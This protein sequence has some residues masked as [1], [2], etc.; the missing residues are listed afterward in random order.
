[1]SREN[2]RAKLIAVASNLLAVEG[3]SGIR[4]AEIAKKAKVRESTIFYHFKDRSDLIEAAQLE[5]YRSTY[6]AVVEPM[7]AALKFSD[8][9]QQWESAVRKV[10][11]DSFVAGREN[12]RSTRTSVLGMAQTSGRLR[13]E[14]VQ[15]NREVIGHVSELIAE[16]S[17]NGWVKS[18]YSPTALASVLMSLIH[19]RSIIEID[20]DFECFSEWN[21]LAID[22]AVQLLTPE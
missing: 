15:I 17:K 9:T 22:L 8:T 7:R 4:L 12:V 13:R 16:A 6:I 3:E 10:L 5:R 21:A 14:V 11:D 18:T 20:H 2:T 1:M 19:G